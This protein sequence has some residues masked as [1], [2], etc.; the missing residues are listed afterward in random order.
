MDGW[1]PGRNRWR[2]KAGSDE[3]IIEIELTQGKVAHIDA[4][5]LEEVQQYKW[6][7]RHSYKDVY[8]AKTTA[9]KGEKYVSFDMHPYLFPNIVA[10]RD[11][12]DHNG[13]NNTHANLRSGADG[14][15][16][17]NSSFK[18]ENRGIKTE[19]KSYRALWTDSLGKKCSKTFTWSKYASRD[20]AYKAAVS[21]R[22]ESERLAVEEITKAHEE[23]RQIESTAPPPRPLKEG[24][25]HRNICI[26]YEKGKFYRVKASIRVNGKR[27]SKM[28]S[29]YQFKDNMED[30]INAANDWLALMQEERNKKRKIDVE[31]DN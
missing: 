25:H 10:P 18:R 2:Y 16:R 28:F 17:R 29:A 12:I 11:H 30:A 9:K 5:R 23:K 22:D 26:L 21:F 14:I 6:S 4:D 24:P 15:N 20:E 19:E 3:K 31:Q 7:T 8:Y 27:I 13:L 1:N